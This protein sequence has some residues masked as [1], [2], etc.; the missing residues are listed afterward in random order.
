MRVNA[1]GERA[2]RRPSGRRRAGACLRAAA[3]VFLGGYS[4]P[5]AAD[6]TAQALEAGGWSESSPGLLMSLPQ[7]TADVRASAIQGDFVLAPGTSLAWERR[8]RGAPGPG[9]VMEIEMYSDGAN[10]SSNDYRRNGAS[11]PVAVTAVFGRDSLDLPL[12]RRVLDFFSGLWHG[13]RPGGVLLTYAAGNVAPVGS[14][15]RTGDEETVFV[16]VGE[17]ERGK[18][19]AVR[20]DLAADFRAAYGRDPRGPVTRVIVRALRPSGERGAIKAG[21]R[22]AFPGT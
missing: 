22:I 15:Y 11:L 12:K 14:M 13:F 8:F 1:C 10:S 9:T 3:V 18:R 7:R 21:I 20:R 4:L 6:N 19:I 5:A 2:G 17:E 16:L